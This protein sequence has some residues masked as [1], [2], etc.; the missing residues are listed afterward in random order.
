MQQQGCRGAA[1]EFLTPNSSLRLYKTGDLAR[2][3]LDSNIEYLGRLDNQVKIRGFRIELGEI[4]AVLSQHPDV[5]E[6]VVMAREDISG[7]KALVG[8][9]VPK[10]TLDRVPYQSE[11]LAQLNGYGTVK[12]ETEDISVGGVCL[13]GVPEMTAQ[14][15]RLCIKLPG[16][17]DSQ[18]FSG[19]IVWQQ[20]KRVGVKFQLAPSQQAIL[21][22]S[23]EYLLK[24]GGFLKVL[25]RTAA[26]SLRNFLKKQLPDY[27][28]PS[29]F[30]FLDALPQTPNG[31]VDRKALPAPEA[32]GSEV[33]TTYIAP[34]TEIE[35]AIAAIWQQVLQL[36]QVGL[37]DNFFDLGG[38]SLRM[39]QVHNQ[40][41]HVLQQE[42]SMVELFQYPTV[43]ALA[44]HLNQKNA[45]QTIFAHS[46]ERANKQKQALHL[47][48]Q[49]NQRKKQNG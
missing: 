5:R 31:K 41:R 28:V 42:V 36:N 33:D 45:A 17:S 48:K 9:I 12:V 22:Q 34:Q 10:Q 6:A 49:K 4:E 3:L 25:Q 30:V 8:Y 43:S 19:E 16:S 39:A 11:C 2:Y 26:Q 27:M 14:N 44:K 46:Q 32:L 47:Q 18:W 15:I 7:D 13:V 38:H 23:V 35:Q 20:G 29:S 1:G 21:N 40:L 24:T 37:H